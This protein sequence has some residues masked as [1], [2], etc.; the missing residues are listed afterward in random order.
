MCSL[1]EI[2][3]ERPE[4]EIV[5]KIKKARKKDKKV[6]RIIEKIKKAEIKMLQGKE[7]QVKRNLVLKK[8]KLYMPKNEELRI[9][10]IQLHHNILV[11]VHEEK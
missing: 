1:H 3:I 2:V 4:V 9:K 5:K 11:I 10:I 6:V 8:G 7:W